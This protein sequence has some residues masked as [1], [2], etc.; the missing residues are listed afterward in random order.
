[1][2]NDLINTRLIT[3]K[4][5]LENLRNVQLSNSDV[6]RPFDVLKPDIMTMRKLLKFGV[7]M[8]GN[9]IFVV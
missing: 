5:I 2:N 7:L 1:M 4:D 3:Y 8:E 6:V 9:K